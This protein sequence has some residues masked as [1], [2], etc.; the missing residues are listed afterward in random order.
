M[1]SLEFLKYSLGIDNEKRLYIT[2]CRINR[3][4][5][6]DENLGSTL[7]RECMEEIGAEIEIGDIAFVRDYIADNH[8]FAEQDPGF[9]LVDIMF[10]CKILNPNSLH[11]QSEP[12]KHQIGFEWLPIR[13]IESFSLYPKSIRDKISHNMNR[14]EKVY[15][16]DVN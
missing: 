2:I 10:L 8:E 4:R 12:D 9:H 7:H 14:S 11:E 6:M 1:I 15:L 16:G 13:E 5:I 3:C